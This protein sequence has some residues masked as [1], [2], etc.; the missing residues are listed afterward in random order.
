[1]CTSIHWLAHKDMYMYSTHIYN[2][3]SFHLIDIIVI[4]VVWYLAAYHTVII[5]ILCNRCN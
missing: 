1:M 2:V 4:V 3:C 5:A